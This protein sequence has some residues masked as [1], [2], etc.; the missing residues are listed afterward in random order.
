MADAI[1]G[2]ADPIGRRLAPAGDSM[3]RRGK[4]VGVAADVKS[5]FPAATPVPFQIYHPTDQAPRHLNELAVLVSGGSAAL[6]V[7]S[8]RNLMTDT[9]P[10]LPL[11]NLQPAN[12]TI[13]R[14]NYQLGVLR[15]MLSAF[16]ILGLPLASLGI[17]GVIARTVALRTGEFG[18]RIALGAQV[19]DILTLV[20]SS[21]VKL[22][23][24]GSILGVIGAYGIAHLFGMAFPNMTME[25]GPAVATTTATLIAVALL[26]SYL[27]PVPKT[28]IFPRVPYCLEFLRPS[29][30]HAICDPD[31]EWD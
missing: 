17:Y 11:R 4:I 16:A 2:A 6:L 10:D 26:A 25:R 15:D 19:L 8:I 21:G 23:F 28:G 3:P 30:L 9:D 29:A 31:L 7:D 22:P 24:I 12:A 1:F 5:I 18:I 27:E 20:R 14:A 13:A